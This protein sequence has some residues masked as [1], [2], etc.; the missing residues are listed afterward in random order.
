MKKWVWAEFSSLDRDYLVKI[1]DDVQN[2]LRGPRFSIHLSL[3][4]PFVDIEQSAIEH[5]RDYCS[6]N[7]SLSVR[8]KGYEHSDVYFQSFYIAIDKSEK[9]ENL[10]YKMFEIN[11]QHS[12]EIFYPHISLAYGNHPS[13]IK[14]DLLSRL[15]KPKDNLVIDKIAIVDIHENISLWHTSNSFLFSN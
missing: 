2:Q 3:A 12:T 6:E 9:L 1:Q 8:T 13:H 4:G 5:V 15:S 7:D 11:K 10:R 14:E